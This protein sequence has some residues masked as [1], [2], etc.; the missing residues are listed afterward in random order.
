MAELFDTFKFPLSRGGIRGSSSLTYEDYIKLTAQDAQLGRRIQGVLVRLLPK[1]VMNVIINKTAVRQ[2]TG[3]KGAKA[4]VVDLTQRTPE[5]AFLELC[6]VP[7]PDCPSQRSSASL[8]VPTERRVFTPGTI[9]SIEFDRLVPF[10]I[11]DC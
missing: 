4:P 6:R 3:L 8:A 1:S 9:P 7:G 5:I 11:E 2:L 10:R